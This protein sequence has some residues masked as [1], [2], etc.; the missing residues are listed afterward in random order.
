MT[1]YY[2]CYVDPQF[3]LNSMIMGN[4]SIDTSCSSMEEP[5]LIP[6]EVESASNSLESASTSSPND[7]TSSAT[8]QNAESLISPA[9]IRRRGW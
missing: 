1:L 5:P 9:V 8:S 3:L 7:G 2:L 6:L 4:N